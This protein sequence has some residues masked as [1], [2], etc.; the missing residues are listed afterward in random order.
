M[1]KR[2]DLLGSSVLNAVK[3]K[4]IKLLSEDLKDSIGHLVAYVSFFECLVN[5]SNAYL[6][7]GEYRI[8]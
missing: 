5:H 7:T 1:K 3:G 6:A 2:C 8:L 4:D